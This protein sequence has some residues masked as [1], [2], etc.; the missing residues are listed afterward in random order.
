M[1]GPAFLQFRLSNLSRFRD[2]LAVRDPAGASAHPSLAG[3]GETVRAHGRFLVLHEYRVPRDASLRFLEVTRDENPIH[4]SGDIV[5]GALTLSK[6]LLHLEVLLDDFSVS[7]VKAKFTGASFYGERTVNH[8]FASPGG[9]PGTVS[10]E[11]VTY[12]AGRMIAKMEIEGAVR[13]ADRRLEERPLR[14]DALPHVRENLSLLRMFH[15]SLGVETQGLGGAFPSAF[16]ASLPSGE[17]VRQ[18]RGEGGMLNVLSLDFGQGAFPISSPTLPEVRLEKGRPGP[19]S[20]SRIRTRIVGGARTYGE[21]FA[22]VN[23]PTHDAPF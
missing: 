15:E 23:R 10:V 2:A 14:R 17:M 13:P 16:L 18:F 6:T 12:Q 1:R 21:G 7:A 22:L 8:Y 20:F 5:P 19:M 9:K 4:V 3:D 11:A